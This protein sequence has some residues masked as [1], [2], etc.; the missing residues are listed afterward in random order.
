MNSKNSTELKR[1][2]RAERPFPWRCAQCEEDQVR[3]A[4]TSYDAEVRYDG[5]LYT[6][7][8]PALEI[9]IC[10]ACGAK[11]FTETVDGQINAALRSHLHLLPPGAIRTALD[12]LSLTQKETAD[13]LGIAEATLSRWLHETQIQSR[14]MDNLM[15]VFFAFPDVRAALVGGRSPALDLETSPGNPNAILPGVEHQDE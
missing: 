14:A 4:T 8:V 1:P 5:R 12:R 11:V 6:F 10:Q 7:T 2:F 3:M 9:P 13:R 15:R